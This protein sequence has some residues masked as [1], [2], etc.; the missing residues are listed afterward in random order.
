[1]STKQ[2]EPLNNDTLRRFA[3]SIFAAQPLPGVSD[4]Y[5]FL[6]TIEVVE[7][8]RSNGWLPVKASEQRI[9]LSAREGFQKHVI[10]FQRASDIATGEQEA[11]RFAPSEHRIVKGEARPEVVL[12]NSHDRSSAYQIHAGLFRLVCSNGL[13]IAD[14]TFAKV[15]V[16]HVDFRPENVIAAS[17][18]VTEQIPQIMGKVEEFRAHRLTD[19]ER[20]AFA[21][22]ALLLK[23]DALETAPVS[24]EK[25]LEA[26]RS[27]DSD[28]SL[29]TTFNTVQENLVNGN[30]KDYGRRL[31]VEGSEYRKRRAPRTRAVNGIDNNVK[32]NKAL[33]HLAETL[34]AGGTPSDAQDFERFAVASN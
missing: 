33:W 21:E 15:S 22:A 12:V 26:R 18:R 23:Y 2:I 29:W 27:A 8:L 7:G 34:R 19:I 6:P 30:Q 24:A 10:R 5:S 3:P 16:R 11:M 28:S 14:A 25:I 1:M 13:I 9:R 31:P 17:F 20:R 4:R 32:L